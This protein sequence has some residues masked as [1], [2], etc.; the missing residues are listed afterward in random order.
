MIWWVAFEFRCQ[1]YLCPQR[2]PE[3]RCPVGAYEGNGLR[4]H[5]SICVLRRAQCYIRS[6]A[7]NGLER[8][9]VS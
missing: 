7:A 8:I 5:T 9:R 2:R 4:Y 1:L 6:V 3:C